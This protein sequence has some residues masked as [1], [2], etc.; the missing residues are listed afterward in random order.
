MTVR[1]PHY[2]S[3]PVRLLPAL[4]LS[5][6]SVFAVT[7]RAEVLSEGMCRAVDVAGTAMYKTA[8]SLSG[9]VN[10]TIT[11]G[12][13]IPIGS[14]VVTGPDSKVVLLFASGAFA[15][16][17]AN[18]E[19]ML[20]GFKQ[21]RL[22]PNEKLQ[23]GAM[24]PSNSHIRMELRRGELINRVRKLRTGSAYEVRTP[25][26]VAGVRGTAFRIKFS[27][28]D[29][30]LSIGVTDGLVGFLANGATEEVS[31]PAGTELEVA[32]SGQGK[33]QMSFSVMSAATTSAINQVIQEAGDAVQQE[34]VPDSAADLA[35]RGKA[36]PA[37]AIP[38]PDTSQTIVSPSS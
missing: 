8:N 27:E 26:G 11:K 32:A 34:L 18:S 15:S 5:I 7:G 30:K 23:P 24:E 36:R 4:L 33:M 19:L 9:E 10:M 37:P 6:W 28:D 29:G 17:G 13:D 12:M 14:I 35:D 20:A 16:L 2:S 3:I 21:D 22:P 1:S 31:I 38:L 25:L